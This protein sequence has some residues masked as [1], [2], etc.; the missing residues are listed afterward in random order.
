M[1]G[2][3]FSVVKIN[4]NGKVQTL[5]MEKG[6]D[7]RLN[8]Q[9]FGIDKNNKQAVFTAKE[10]DRKEYPRHGGY[11]E[12]FT[13]G[14]E[15]KIS[16]EEFKLLK[17][18]A[19]NVNEG[20]GL[21]LSKKDVDK[22]I[23][24]FK[25]GNFTADIKKG[26]SD[27]YVFSK[28]SQDRGEG[29]VTASIDS[30]N[31]KVTVSSGESEYEGCTTIN[32]LSALSKLSKDGRVYDGYGGEGDIAGHFYYYTD[33]QGRE[34]TMAN[35]GLDALREASVVYTTN[36]GKKI[37]EDYELNE[38]IE[39]YT[40]EDGKKVCTQYDTGRNLRY[41][42]IEYT[43][44]GKNVY[45]SYGED[46]YHG[47]SVEYLDNN[48]DKVVERYDKN[49]KLKRREGYRFTEYYNSGELAKREIYED[50]KDITLDY[51]NGEVVH[52]RVY[53]RDDKNEIYTHYDKD[54]NKSVRVYDRGTNKLN[55]VND[56]NVAEYAQE[57]EFSELAKEY[58]EKFKQMSPK[59]IAD[60]MKS[61]IYGPSRKEKTLAM[62][63]AIPNEKLAAVIGAYNKDRNILNDAQD[64]MF[65]ALSDESG[66]DIEKDLMPRLKTAFASYLRGKN[67]DE[68]DIAMAEKINSYSATKDSLIEVEKF[69]AGNL[70]VKDEDGK[71]Q[72][73]DYGYL[74]ST[75]G[76]SLGDVI[77]HIFRN[78]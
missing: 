16:E 62:F 58:N 20:K 12:V 42:N 1:A 26:F 56:F 5:K 4:V 28:D 59:E 60:K 24:L 23:E 74:L 9:Y 67:A 3:D 78:D 34:V 57:G 41:R 61:Q 32:E 37:T 77:N 40:T 64:S 31:A 53:E 29:Y 55:R 47:K 33:K 76:K 46:G 52:K 18:I 63:D 51:K 25:A 15:I 43:E 36:D 48:G 11:S 68:K 14:K 17:N 35:D 7:V 22:A 50:G 75:G 73:K 21:A 66:I 19:D 45:E 65:I 38:I 70:Y 49:N 8:S 39:E 69:F 72:L 2:N 54:G 27:K 71:Y 6:V 30:H 10:S 13:P 44:N